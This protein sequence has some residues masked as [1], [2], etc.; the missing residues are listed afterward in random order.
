MPFAGDEQRRE[1]ARRIEQANPGW[2]VVWGVYSHEYVAFPLFR[3]P[4]G[5]VLSSRN[6]NL[7]AARMRQVEFTFSQSG[8]P[9]G[10]ADADSLR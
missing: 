4:S 8:K 1:M 9:E 2:L 6:F 7:L 10:G 3:V 5:I